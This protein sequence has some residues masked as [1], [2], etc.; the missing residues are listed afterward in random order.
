MPNFGRTN[1]SVKEKITVFRTTMLT[2]IFVSTFAHAHNARLAEDGC[3]NAKDAPTHCH[4]AKKVIDFASNEA[5]YYE[6][7]EIID[8]DTLDFVYGYGVI[9]VRLFGVDTPETKRGTKLTNDAKAILKDKG[10]EPT[11]EALETEKENQLQLGQEAKAYVEETLSGK[12]VYVMFDNTDEFP[13]IL[14]GKYGRYL[15]YLFYCEGDTVHFLNIDLIA[16]GHADVDY[17]STPFRYRWAFVSDLNQA[18]ERFAETVLPNDV[19]NA[20]SLHRKITATWA[21]LKL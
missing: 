8:G 10:I 9:K 1:A 2:L 16:T 7:S 13:F 17:V 6:I 14:Q 19:P 15:A 5:G 21:S 4:D 20:P 12:Q 11:Q 3:H 18:Q